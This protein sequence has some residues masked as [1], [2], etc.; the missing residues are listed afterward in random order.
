MKV[1]TS[2]KTKT[3]LISV[4]RGCGKCTVLT[5]GSTLLWQNRKKTVIRIFLMLQQTNDMEEQ[6]HQGQI[7]KY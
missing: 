5:K 3:L 6:E 7:I 2:V 1:V 4:F